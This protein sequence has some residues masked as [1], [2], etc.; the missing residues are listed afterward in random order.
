V[1]AIINL[2]Q[3]DGEK[4]LKEQYI[5]E[6]QLDVKQQENNIINI[7]PEVKYQNIEG[8]GGAI[9]EAVGYTLSK[10]SPSLAE[11][12]VSAYFSEDGN[13]YKFIRTHLDSCDF[14]LNNY[15]AVE[16]PC[17]KE[18]QSF[19]LEGHDS[20]YIIPLIYKAN[21]IAK[22]SLPV[23]LT[24]WSPPAFMKTNGER[25][26]GGN[27]RKDCYSL[28][29][30]YI[31][32]YIREYISM[33][34]NITMLSIQNEPKA[35]QLWDS[36]I[37]TA[38][39]EKEFVKLHLYPAL[40]E[41]GLGHIQLFIWDHNKER[42]YDRACEVI[43]A[44]TNKMVAGVSFHWY[45]GDHFDAVRLVKSRFP[46]KKLV[47]SEGCIEYSHS[48]GASQLHNAQ[49][50]AHDMIGNLNSGMNLFL[51]WNIA[52]DEK[53]GPNHAGNYCDA[54]II[55]DTL[56]NSIDK[57]LSFDYIGHFSRY[58]KPGAVRIATTQYTDALE[59][60][61]AENPDKSITIVVLNRTAEICN[62]FIRLRE[63]LL[64]L[65]IPAASISSI[66]IN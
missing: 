63:H 51:D 8:F 5:R 53:G 23:M 56:N 65:Y 40:K 24:P 2:T 16:D 64:P 28:W 52:L 46:E 1:Q 11:E 4:A 29:A 54:P 42:I 20:K 25:N 55:C 62:A 58:I 13:R 43:D 57:R 50:Y 47:F 19:S 60:T 38:E 61:A 49:R 66:V 37:F 18:F 33:K 9:T 27:L 30:K 3:F 35:V 21:E 6:F 7:Y 15:S 10:L 14:S 59:L 34:C 22:E 26:G 41:N 17:D 36:C 39:E 32:R 44:D 48:L 45:S 12:V 31:C